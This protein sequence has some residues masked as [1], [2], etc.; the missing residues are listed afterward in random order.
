[1]GDMY[2]QGERINN[3]LITLLKGIDNNKKKDLLNEIIRFGQIAK[4]RCR[5]NTAYKNFIDTTFKNIATAEVV[6]P[7]GLEF[8]VIQ[9]K[10]I[11]E[12]IEW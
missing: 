3:N 6:R 7:E 12:E 9:I 5:S 1:M 10:E 8:D 11:I 4:F 2:S